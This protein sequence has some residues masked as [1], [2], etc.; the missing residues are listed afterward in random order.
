MSPCIKF[1]LAKSLLELD[2]QAGELLQ[3]EE[4]AV[5]FA[6]HVCEHLKRENKQSTSNSSRFLEACDRFNRAEISHSQLVDSTDG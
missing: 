4:L 6:R 5:P 2:K 1:A 3:L